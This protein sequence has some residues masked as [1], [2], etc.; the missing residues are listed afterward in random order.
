MSVHQHPDYKQ[1]QQ[2]LTYAREYITSILSLADEE[3]QKHEAGMKEAFVNL[4]YLDSSLSYINILTNARLLDMLKNDVRSLAKVKDQPYFGRVDFQKDHTDHP[5]TYYIGK[6]SLYRKDTQEPIIVDWRSPVSQIYYDGRIGEVSYDSGETTY[7][8]KL[9]KKRQYVMGAG[10]LEEIRD[11]D[12]TT[13]DELLQKSLQGASDQRINEIVATIQSEQNEVIRADLTKP[14]VVQGV[15]GS[16]KTTIALHRLSYFIYNYADKVAPEEMMILA[17]NEM[18]IGYIA[19]ALPELGVDRIEQSTYIQYV[20]KCLGKNLRVRPAVEELEVMIHGTEQEQKKRA[21]IAE[22]KGSKRFEQVIQ[23]YLTAIRNQYLPSSPFKLDQFKVMSAKRLKKLFID[24]YRYLPFEKRKEKIGQLLKQ[25]FKTKKQEVLAHIEDQFE[26]QYDK[27]ALKIK[28]PLVRQQQVS[29]LID[30][31]DFL[32]ER[33]KKLTISEV[34]T[35]LK[36]VPSQTVP[37]HYQALFSDREMFQ[38]YLDEPLTDEQIDWLFEEAANTVMKHR[39]TL[40]DLAPLLMMQVRI[41]G[42]DPSLKKKYVVIDEAQDYSLFQIRSLIRATGTKLF[43]M[44]GDLTQGIYGFRGI[45][46]WSVLI[47]QALPK[48]EKYYLKKSYRTTIEIMDVANRLVELSGERY[49]PS[50]PVVRHG[51]MPQFHSAK[52]KADYQAVVEKVLAAFREKGHKNIALITKSP[53]EVKQTAKILDQL[54]ETYQVLTEQ[55]TLQANIVVVPVHLAKGLEFDA[56]MLVQW[57]AYYQQTALDCKLLYVAVT[58][59]MHDVAFVGPAR[60]VF[61]LDQ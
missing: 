22:F 20:E 35:Y 53:E 36:Q 57:K 43:N 1:E 52:T 59:A 11:I 55:A 30:N 26:K 19:Q 41:Y 48:A 3:Q 13:R 34:T 37:K 5:V 29:E 54:G 15:A 51:D 47:N 21:F 50:E 32:L 16:G 42:I 60:S 38:S 23:R 40:D 17:P 27:L 46:D 18:F 49:P 6:V 24:D 14:M 10:E 9:T 44:L 12:M 58:R 61:L 56:A 7:H 33:I 45:T 31:K 39:Y 25:S 2:Y 4:D 8:G 28:D